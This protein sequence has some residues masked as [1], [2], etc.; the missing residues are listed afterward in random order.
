MNMFSC[1]CVVGWALIRA[2]DSKRGRELTVARTKA[3]VESGEILN[4]LEKEF[5]TEFDISLLDNGNRAELLRDWQDL[6]IAVNERRKFGVVNDGMCLLVA[7]TLEGLQRR[8]R[9]IE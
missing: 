2:I 3:M 4:F 6:A 7:Y 8:K 1:H 9:E 5:G